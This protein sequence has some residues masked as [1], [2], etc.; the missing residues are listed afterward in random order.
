MEIHTH[1]HTHKHTHT[2]TH[3]KRYL[4][5]IYFR[6][7]AV[8]P[9]EKTPS[10]EPSAPGATHHPQ[11]PGSADTGRL[12]EVWLHPT[13]TQAPPGQSPGSYR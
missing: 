12:G 13:S 9:G 1:T 8:G 10:E 3:V 7:S 4:K 2:Y 5:T 11:P 6:L